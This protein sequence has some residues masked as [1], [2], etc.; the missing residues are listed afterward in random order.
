M[1]PGAQLE[2]PAKYFIMEKSLLESNEWICAKGNR[3]PRGE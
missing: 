1:S 2:I 3:G